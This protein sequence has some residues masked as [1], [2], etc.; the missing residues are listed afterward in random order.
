MS[1]KQDMLEKIKYLLKRCLFD[2]EIIREILTY[3]LV[4]I[5]TYYISMI[6][7]GQKLKSCFRG[8]VTR[9]LRNHA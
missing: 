4:A 9:A 5:I 3:D 2:L 7:W 1:Q 8:Y 6:Q